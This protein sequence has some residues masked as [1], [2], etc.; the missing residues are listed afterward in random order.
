MDKL[1]WMAL[2]IAGLTVA[3]HIP[4][5]V[6]ALGSP[7]GNARWRRQLAA[8]LP[9]LVAIDAVAGYIGWLSYVKVKTGSNLGWVVVGLTIAAVAIVG[10]LSW[11][12]RNDVPF[13]LL[14]AG[15]LTF[16]AVRCCIA[17]GHLLG[18]IPQH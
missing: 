11:G 13:G 18:F 4:V 3:G 5:V 9:I 8:L 12:R 17:A 16:T 7:R 2:G 1:L 15:V 14:A 6:I 10:G